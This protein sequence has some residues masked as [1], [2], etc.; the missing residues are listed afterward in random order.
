MCNHMTPLLSDLA[1]STTSCFLAAFC[2]CL[3]QLYFVF[4]SGYWT[5]YTFRKL[6]NFI[7]FE[8]FSKWRLY[9]SLYSFT[10]ALAFSS[11]PL[12]FHLGLPFHAVHCLY[13]LTVY[14]DQCLLKVSSFLCKSSFFLR[15]SRYFSSFITV[16]ELIV[17]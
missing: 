4:F 2:S 16:E 9:C 17:H 10:K 15:G 13:L 5:F 1:I 3:T 6:L 8:C 12:L 7:F 11:L 14:F